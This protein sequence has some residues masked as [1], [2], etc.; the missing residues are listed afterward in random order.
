MSPTFEPEV[1]ELMCRKALEPQGL[2]VIK[3]WVDENGMGHCGAAD[4][5]GRVFLFN[6]KPRGEL[7]R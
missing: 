3:F 6:E 7:Q 4:A 1:K 5:K 2:R